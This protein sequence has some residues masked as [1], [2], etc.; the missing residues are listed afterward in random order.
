MLKKEEFKNKTALL[1]R[2]AVFVLSKAKLFFTI[3]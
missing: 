3:P 2:T 1:R